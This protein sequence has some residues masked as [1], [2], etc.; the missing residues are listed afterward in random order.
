MVDWAKRIT[1]AASDE[2]RAGESV[3]AGTLFQ[4]PGAT[5]RMTGV[6]VGGLLGAAVAS[7]IR[8][9]DDGEMVSDEGIAATVPDGPLVVGLTSGDR[10]LLYTQGSMSGKPK[11]LAAALARSDVGRRYVDVRADEALADQLTR[12]PARDALEEAGGL[13]SRI[14]D[15]AAL[16]A[17]KRN[18]HDRA[19]V[20]H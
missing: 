8:K 9:D 15:H 5:G 17:A 14:D 2:L 20:G 1:K 12:V 19:L 7:K 4:P 6:A 10:I 16:G 3:V 18:V 13:I 11:E